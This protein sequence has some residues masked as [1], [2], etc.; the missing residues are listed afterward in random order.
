MVLSWGRSEAAQKRFGLRRLLSILGFWAVLSPSI[1]SAG[2][3]VPIEVYGKLPSIEAPRLSPDGQT[4]AFLSSVRGRRCLVIHPL[5]VGADSGHAVCPGNYEVRSFAWKN[6]DRLIVE[7][8]TQG[9]SHGDELRTQSRLVALDLN[10]RDAVPLAEPATERAVDFGQDRII[11]ML[12]DDPG[13]VLVAAYRPDGDSP[14]VVKVAIETGHRR[15]VVTGQDRIMNWKTDAQGEVRVGV[16]VDDGMIKVYYRDDADGPFRLIRQVPAADASKF[17]VLAIGRDPGTLWVASTERTGFRAVYRYDVA[18]DR[19]LDA[20]ASVPGADIDSLVVDRGLPL[21]YGYTVDEP[22][23][24]YTDASFRLDAEQV[25]AALPQYHATVVDSAADGRRLLVL[26]GGGNRPG[27]Y[28]ILTRARNTATLEPLGAIRPDIPEAALAPVTPVAYAARD[29][30][31]IHGYVTLPP[32]RS[33]ADKQP[34]PFVVLPH[35]GPSTRDVLGFDYLAQMIASQGYGVLQ[36]NYR[37]SRGYGG[38][39]EKAGF[40]QWGL[41]MQDDV[42]DGTQ[43]LIDRK[44]ADPRRIC[45]VGWSYGGYT[46][47]MGAIKTPSLY[48]CAASMAGVSDLR[49]RLDRANQSRFADINLPRF[50]S[51]PAII[52]ANSPVLHADRIQIPVFL[53]HGRRDFTVSVEDS[54]AME[55]ALRRLGKPVETLYFDDDDHYL[56]REGDRIAFLKALAGFLTANLGPGATAGQGATATN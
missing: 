29:G 18:T 19:L 11:D 54:E 35:G 4:M 7:V 17:A 44:L 46:A 47:L 34:I 39:F 16:A 15:T 27:A 24:I 56:F 38:D 42:T 25:A 36:P 2:E 48:R 40:A 41:K 32:G 21:G 10:G 30:L 20:Y 45:V 43:W 5:A 28:F 49:R 1:A 51:D 12:P 52:D 53:A 31:T 8:Y 3:R 37:G 55:D 50:D 22:T 33:M 6:P 13:H 14:D 23:M 26:A 9:Q